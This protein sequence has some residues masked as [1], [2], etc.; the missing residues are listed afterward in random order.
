MGSTVY[1]AFSAGNLVEGAKL[2]RLVHPDKAITVCA[3]D[4]AHLVN[5]PNIN[6]NIGMDAAHAAAT[7][8]GALVAVPTGSANHGY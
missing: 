1:A 5:H 3:D 8:I 7:A 2:V 6:R 4:D